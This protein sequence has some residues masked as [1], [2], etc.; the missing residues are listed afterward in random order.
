MKISHDTL[1]L[2]KNFAGIN[3][4]I[5]VRQDNVLLVF[6]TLADDPVRSLPYQEVLGSVWVYHDV[7]LIRH[8]GPVHSFKVYGYISCACDFFCLAVGCDHSVVVC[9]SIQLDVCFFC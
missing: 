1:A 7:E 8:C 4:N 5:L 3:T 9:V 6:M 2:L